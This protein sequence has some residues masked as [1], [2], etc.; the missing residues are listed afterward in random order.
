MGEGGHRQILF[1][2][3]ASHAHVANDYVHT[4]TRV[5]THTACPYIL[6]SDYG[7]ENASLAAIQMAFRF[8]DNDEMAGEKSFMYGPSKS[9][10]IRKQYNLI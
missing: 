3:H 7:T 2:A 10:I 4:H 1:F 5:Q 9:N 8:N 6:R